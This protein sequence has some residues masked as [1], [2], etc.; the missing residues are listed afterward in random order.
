[1]QPPA[2][3]SQTTHTR[4]GGIEMSSKQHVSR[5]PFFPIPAPGETVYSLTGRFMERTGL[6]QR[7]LNQLLS[8]NC[9]QSPFKSE[10]TTYIDKLP[11]IMPLGHPWTDCRSIIRNHSILPYYTYFDSLERS[12]EWETKFTEFAESNAIKRRRISWF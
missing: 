6:S 9:S 11:P 3:R 5:L 10:L 1:M 4:I 2:T 8:E 12:L 7:V